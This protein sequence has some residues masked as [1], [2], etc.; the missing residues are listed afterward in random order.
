MTDPIQPIAWLGQNAALGLNNS[1]G[2]AKVDITVHL[3]PCPD[4]NYPIYSAWTV[5]YL[6]MQNKALAERCER[7]EA[8]L[9]E[10]ADAFDCRMTDWENADFHEEYRNAVALLSR[11]DGGKE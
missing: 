7:L 9:R 2:Y 4:P 3:K 1:G 11:S 8:A 6:E 5:R 10:L